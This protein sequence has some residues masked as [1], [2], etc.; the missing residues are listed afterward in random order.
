MKGCNASSTL[1]RQI[2]LFC[3]QCFFGGYRTY[4]RLTEIRQ[5]GWETVEAS[6]HAIHPG[7]SD[8][9]FIPAEAGIQEVVCSWSG[10]VAE[11]LKYSLALG[12]IR[13]KTI[14]P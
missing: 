6:S 13:K 3:A 2:T 12:C 1:G 8:P 4:L 9:A 11:G 5:R 7:K 10:V 14:M